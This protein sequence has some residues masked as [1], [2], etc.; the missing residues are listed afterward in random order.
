MRTWNAV[1]LLRILIPFVAGIL[2]AIELPVIHYFFV[3]A[4]FILFGC[5]LLFTFTRVWSSSYRSSW[6]FGIF[7]NAAFFLIAYQLTIFKT[8]QFSAHHFSK[9]LIASQIVRVRVAS[10]CVEKEKSVKVIVEFLEVKDKE[11]QLPVFGKAIVYFQ[12][13]AR[14]L[15]L[16]SGDELILKATFKEIERVQ[17]PGAFDYRRFLFYKNIYGQAYLK[18][19]DWVHTGINSE[20]AIVKFSIRLRNKLLGI[21]KEAHLKEDE[22]AVAAALLVGYTDKLDEELLTAYSQTGT[23]HV[24]SVSGMHVAIVFMV[25]SRFL[26]FLDKIKHGAL[27]KTI[28]LIFF[29]WFYALLTGL[30]P[31]V[32]RSATMFSFI[33]CAKSFKRNSTIFN[34]LAASALFLLLFN[35]YLI[36]DVGFQLSYLAVAGIV[37][38]QPFFDR[39]IKE[40]N[41]IVNQV[42][43][44]ITVSI[45][46]QLA[47]LPVSLYYFHQFPNYFLL[48]N[49][50]V[51]PLSTCII[52]MGMLLIIISGNAFLLN[53]ASLLFSKMVGF[54]NA[55]VVYIRYLPYAITDNISIDAMEVYLMYAFII[56]L[57]LYVREKKY[58]YLKTNLCILIIGLGFQVMKQRK[59]QQQKKF[60]V[61]A[62]PKMSVI[63]FISAQEHVLVTD[64]SYHE[65]I[66][67][68]YMKPNW[69]NLGLQEPVVAPT[70]IKTST[71]FVK[72]EAIQF[73]TKRIIILKD[74]GKIK[75]LYQ[76]GKSMV[77]DYVIVSKNVN[78]RMKEVLGVYKPRCVVFDL[79]NS[80]YRI[81]KWEKECRVLHQLYY[82]I[83][84]SGAYIAEL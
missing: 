48:S 24:L 68:K 50:I 22:F 1:P 80:F 66:G 18:T 72:D 26:F 27:I 73:Y 42:S 35:P 81:K 54:L 62:I 79:S 8:D 67:I 40:S 47:T 71:L 23:L 10:S 33:V 57:F 39:W 44:L 59:E 65:K 20:Y 11:I 55:A 32:L 74:A 82:S 9:Q 2:A 5:I 84:D 6:W 46:A 76:E 70:N 12:K 43:T 7:M 69:C 21:F 63:D 34:T 3:V 51:I 77:V 78:V 61:Y 56:F 60:I 30:S 75:V 52:Y 31:S 64:T 53:Y 4:L 28:V 14:S 38:I 83:A 25:F 16:N 45:A 49:L 19:N 13:D 17:N 58:N 37:M 41:W 36:M 15:T 29:L